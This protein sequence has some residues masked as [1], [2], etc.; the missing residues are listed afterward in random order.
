MEACTKLLNNLGESI[1]KQKQVCI[2]KSP[3][4]KD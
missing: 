1:T 3:L 2:L 4:G